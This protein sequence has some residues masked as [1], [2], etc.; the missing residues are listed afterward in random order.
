[1]NVY[2]KIKEVDY[3]KGFF[4]M[5][6]CR[7]ILFCCVNVATQESRGFRAVIPRAMPFYPISRNGITVMS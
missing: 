5:F 6:L 7:D 4:H 3:Q 1:M 2:D